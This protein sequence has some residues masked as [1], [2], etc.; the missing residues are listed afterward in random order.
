[1]LIFSFTMFSQLV[2]N[3]MLIWNW[4]KWQSI[5]FPQRVERFYE[6]FV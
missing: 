2:H 6:S 3:L 1:M 4:R 5:E